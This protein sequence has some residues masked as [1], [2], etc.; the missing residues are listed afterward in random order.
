MR[1]R[2]DDDVRVELEELLRADAGLPAELRGEP[3]RNVNVG[4]R[5]R[6]EGVVRAECHRALST[7]EAAAHDPD[8]QRRGAHPWMLAY[9]PPN[10][11]SK[12]S[13][14]EPAAAI[15]WRVSAGRLA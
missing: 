13:S 4:V 8:P 6:D 9:A 2:H 15:A 11:K 10:S 7:D 14:S 1:R 12:T 3:V 5:A